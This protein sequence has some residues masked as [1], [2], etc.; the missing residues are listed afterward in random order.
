M[1]IIRVEFSAHEADAHGCQAVVHTTNRALCSSVR[2]PAPPSLGS[3]SS[4]TR[5]QRLIGESHLADVR[6][7]SLHSRPVFT[8]A[9]NLDACVC[10]PIIAK[11]SCSLKNSFVHTCTPILALYVWSGCM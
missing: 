3:E 4:H 7:G 9:C 5:V 6:P 8:Q 2:P 11:H 10:P 1:R